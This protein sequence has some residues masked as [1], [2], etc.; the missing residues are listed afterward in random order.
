M[1]L[2]RL[3][4][5]VLCFIERLTLYADRQVFSLFIEWLFDSQSVDLSKTGS[6]DENVPVNL[7]SLTLNVNFSSFSI[8]LRYRDLDRADRPSVAHENCLSS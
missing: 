3:T 2:C 8:Q 7:P 4:R 1:N 5:R 6:L